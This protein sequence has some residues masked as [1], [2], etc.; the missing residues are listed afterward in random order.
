M[1]QWSYYPLLFIF[2]WFTFT[3]SFRVRELYLFPKL[4]PSRLQWKTALYFQSSALYSLAPKLDC[5][6]RLA[7]G[8]G[9]LSALVA[10]SF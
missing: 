8:G 9:L 1:S 10:Y 6:E 4:I 2:P 5:G 3:S 7:T